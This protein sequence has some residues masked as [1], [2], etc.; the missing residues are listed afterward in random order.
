MMLNLMR[1]CFRRGIFE[2]KN[3]KGISID[4]QGVTNLEVTPKRKRH[5]RTLMAGVQVF[6]HKKRWIPAKRIPESTRDKIET[7]QKSG[8]PYASERK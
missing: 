3:D 7:D 2:N 4:E 6:N 1:I 5:S 8:T